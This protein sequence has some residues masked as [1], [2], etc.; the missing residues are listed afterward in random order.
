MPSQEHRHWL[1]GPMLPGAPKP[2]W[3]P[4]GQE[5]CTHTLPYDVHVVGT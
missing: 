4:S 2:Q 3:D 1:G 5:P